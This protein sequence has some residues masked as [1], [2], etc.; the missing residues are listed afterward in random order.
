MADGLI[1]QEQWMGCYG[2]RGSVVVYHYTGRV[3]SARDAER[4]PLHR[5]LD[6]CVHASLI[7]ALSTLWGANRPGFYF[8]V[9][10][11]LLG[12]HCHGYQEFEPG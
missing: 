8:S 10:D 9:G 1:S 11:F 6:V 7:A 5:V 12:I 2:L 3:G 4:G